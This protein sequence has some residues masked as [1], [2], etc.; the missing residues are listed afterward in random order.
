MATLI[1]PLVN[2][3]LADGVDRRGSHMQRQLQYR[4]VR[5][6]EAR[7]VNILISKRL[8]G[9]GPAIGEFRWR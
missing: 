5:Q 8:E 2:P 9:K 4:K 7:G 3:I 1:D 6:A